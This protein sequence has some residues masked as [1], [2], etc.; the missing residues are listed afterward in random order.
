MS[1]AWKGYRGVPEPG[2]TLCRLD[3][4]P[5]PGTHCISIDGFPLLLVR[6]GTVLTAFVNA[7]P[8]QYLP[9]NHRGES[10]LS[11]DGR[12]LRCTN[13]AAGFDVESGAGVDGLGLGECLDPVPVVLA[14]EVVKIA[15]G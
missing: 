15:M 14:G 12:T 2:T 13:H 7:C 10:L 1:D 3:A 9:L 6:Q 5:N 11:S 8:H 4:V